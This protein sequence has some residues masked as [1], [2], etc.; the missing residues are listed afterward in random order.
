M[1]SGKIPAIYMPSEE[2]NIAKTSQA[3]SDLESRPRG[4]L[5]VLPNFF[6]FSLIYRLASHLEAKGREKLEREKISLAERHT[7]EEIAKVKSRF[8]SSASS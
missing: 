6:P 4:C 8:L 3:D 7:R 2:P 5:G 1:P